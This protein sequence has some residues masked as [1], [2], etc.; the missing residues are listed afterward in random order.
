MTTQ[1]YGL[2]VYIGRFQPFHQ[3]HAETVS[4]ALTQAERVLVL[5]G[6]SNRARSGKNP[7]TWEERAAMIRAAFPSVDEA[8]LIIHPLPDAVY[9]PA[10]WVLMVQS[11][12]REY[13]PHSGIG[14]IGHDKDA[15]SWYLKAFPDWALL[16]QPAFGA[17][18]ATDLRAMLLE[19]RKSARSLVGPGLLSPG[20][21]AWISNWAHTQP[22]AWEAMS[23]EARLL[24]DYHEAW[25]RCP[26]PPTF[27][28]ADSVVTCQNHVL[29][30]R[31]AKAPGKGL[32]AM[33]G[34]FLDQKETLAACAVRE[35]EEET[36]LV[37][38]ESAI[39]DV[40]MFDHPD[41]SARGRTIT[42]VH[43]IPLDAGALPPLNAGDD[44]STAEWVPIA[45]ALSAPTALFEDHWFILHAIL[46]PDRA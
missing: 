12:A 26:Y 27:V 7:W 35:L 38:G 23:Q 4:R 9:D 21:G 8:R 11:L 10:A 37:L 32:W 28:T 24:R 2:L 5:V 14:L 16:E 19:Q 13:A 22:D 17:L 18:N 31:R 33:P 41:R 34:G 36:G 43:R 15:S 30:V 20:V 29:L 3:A 44:A 42:H 25:A 40:R 46:Q 1:K 39:R 6:S 45:Q